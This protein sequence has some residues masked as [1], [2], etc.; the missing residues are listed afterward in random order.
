M[1]NLTVLANECRVECV[2]GSIVEKVRIFLDGES[3]VYLDSS[4]NAINGRK[5]IG[6]QI[7]GGVSI[8]QLIRTKEMEK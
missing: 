1:S 4:D 8:F 5:M 3:L 6:G 7:I 2:D